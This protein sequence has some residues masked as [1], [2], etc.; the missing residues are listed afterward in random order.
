MIQELLMRGVKPQKKFE[1]PIFM[2]DHCS[3]N[4]LSVQAHELFAKLFAM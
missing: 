4:G 1:V 3:V 2:A